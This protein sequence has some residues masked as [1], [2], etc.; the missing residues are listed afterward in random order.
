M[1]LANTFGIPP[2]KNRSEDLAQRLNAGEVGFQFFMQAST[3][4][5]I[6]WDDRRNI[7]F[8]NKGASNMFGYTAEEVVGQPLS[9]ILPT[10]NQ[11]SY[12]PVM[13]H[14]GV[15]RERQSTVKSVEMEGIRKHGEGFPIEMSLSRSNLK[16]GTFY[17]GIIRDISSR[18]EAGQSMEER[19]RLLALE[20]E[21][22]HVL[23]RN[24]ALK[25]L[26][27]D[28]AKALVRHLD[29]ALAT[30]WTRGF[31]QERLELQATAGLHTHVTSRH[32]PV[33]FGYQKI[34]QI[35]S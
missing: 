28:C 20:A 31:Q 14:E 25:S 7:L 30:I 12:L 16:D 18:K 17:C 23:S 26:W 24:C 4:A 1:T 5:I 2:S 34:E 8:W 22:G 3:D 33:P 15:L 32:G 29:A 13:Q 19:N 11:D 10:L 27:T 21:I 9:R 35:G 6:L